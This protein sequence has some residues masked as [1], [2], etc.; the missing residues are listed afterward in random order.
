MGT[1]AYMAPENAL[2]AREVGPEADVFGVGVIAYQLLANR[3]PHAV[4]PVWTRMAGH[5]APPVTP[6]AELRRICRRR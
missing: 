5:E 1:P 4:P 2:G 6:L 3:L